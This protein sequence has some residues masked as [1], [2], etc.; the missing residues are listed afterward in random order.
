[1]SATSNT[2]PVYVRMQHFNSA[3]FLDK[4]PA[5]SDAPPGIVTAT[6]YWVVLAWDGFLQT[7][8]WWSCQVL[9]PVLAAKQIQE[10]KSASSEN[11]PPREV[12]GV[13][14][15]VSKWRKKVKSSWNKTTVACE[16]NMC[17][18][19]FACK[20]SKGSSR[21]LIRSSAFN[22]IVWVKIGLY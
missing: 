20:R 3:S 5:A 16:E 2:V 6:I 12:F 17:K 13:G 8:Q 18:K 7:P 1:M 21:Q 11:H 10:L 22:G 9:L 19:F 15:H 14:G 4:L